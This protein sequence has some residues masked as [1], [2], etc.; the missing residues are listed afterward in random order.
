MPSSASTAT[1]TR[2][3]DRSPGSEPSTSRRGVA[4]T[5]ITSRRATV[6]G[7]QHFQ[8]VPAEQAGREEQLGHRRIGAVHLDRERRGDRPRP[9]A[10]TTSRGR[11]HYPQRPLPRRPGREPGTPGAS[12]RRDR[13]AALRAPHSGRC[14]A[15]APARRGTSARATGAGAAPGRSRSATRPTGTSGSSRPVE[16]PDHFWQA[17][18]G[19]TIRGKSAGE[20]GTPPRLVRLCPEPPRDPHGLWRRT[21]GGPALAGPLRDAWRRPRGPP[22]GG[23]ELTDAPAEEF[24]EPDGG[25]VHLLRGGRT[26][27]ASGRDT[28][29]GRGAARPGR[30]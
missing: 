26:A 1:S 9:T 15:S 24:L 7:P 17:G 21:G 22:H 11:R 5:A 8:G 4:A 18:H 3:W 10:A 25:R 19:G 29:S 27:A 14:L 2:W 6:T 13:S 20:A 30:A 23:D 28:W 12:A 16:Q